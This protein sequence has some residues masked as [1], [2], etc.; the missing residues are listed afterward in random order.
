MGY[1]KHFRIDH[2]RNEF[3]KGSTHVNGIEGFWGF[4]KTRLSRFRGM[5][6]STFYLHLKECEFRLNYRDQDLY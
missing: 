6:K 4:S 5:S 3:A 2:G 1:G